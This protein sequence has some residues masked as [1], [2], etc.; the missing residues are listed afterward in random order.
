MILFTH[1]VTARLEYIA[2]FIAKEIGITSFRITTNADEFRQY[3]G[4]CINYSEARILAH[5]IWI[6]PHGLLFEKNIRVQQTD[7]FTINGET[8]FFATEGTSRYILKTSASS[9]PKLSMTY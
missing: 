6:K 1:T 9:M 3:D 7:C 2:S 8:A 4:A 5:E